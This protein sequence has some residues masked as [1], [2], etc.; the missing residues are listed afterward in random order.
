M[1]DVPR[2]SRQARL[3]IKRVVPRPVLDASRLAR[4][5][6]RQ[7]QQRAFDA[8]YGL[9][10]APLVAAQHTDATHYEATP[11]R[12]FRRIVKHLKI[13][14]ED[15]TFV[16][17]GSGKGAVLLYAASF[18]FK[19]IVGIER[20]RYLHEIALANVERYCQ[21]SGTSRA[22]IEA[23]CMDARDYPFAAE[24]T[25]M[26]LANPFGRRILSDLVGNIEHSPSLAARSVYVLYYLPIDD[27]FET[28]QRFRRLYSGL[29][30]SV[31]CANEAS[32]FLGTG[33]SV[34][35]VAVGC[36]YPSN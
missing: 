30:Y 35:P 15:F 34:R 33:T 36:D 29:N 23:L 26:Y 9:D 12:V 14:Y 7:Q 31:Y 17:I 10:T 27:V 28:S 11:T 5:S 13:H 24:P 18:S 32:R 8:K 21:H 1:H 6:W 22:R 2:L 19:R 3:W 4:H 25:V 16:D 20:S